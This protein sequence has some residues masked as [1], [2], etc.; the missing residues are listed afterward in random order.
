MASECDDV[1]WSDQK[2]IW[3]RI[4][5]AK[6]SVTR[7][8]T[9]IDKLTGCPFIYSM[10]AACDDTRK[11]LTEAFDFCVELHDRWSDLENE[12]GN[13]TASETANKSLA[14]YEEKQF[15]AL[16]KLTECVDKH[17]KSS[18]PIPSTSSDVTS[19]SVGTVPKL[20]TCKILF[21]KELTKENTPSEFRLW[22]AAYR[23]FHEASNLKLQPVAMQ[24]WYL[25]QALS[26][27]LQE[28]VERKLTLSMPLFGPA[29]CLDILQGEF[30]ILYPI[31]NRRVDFFQVAREPGENSEEYLRRLSSLA[32]MANLRAMTQEELTTFRFIGSCNDKRLRDKIFELK[33]KRKDTTAVRDAVAQYELQQK[34][35]AALQSK[36]APIAA[37]QQAQQA[38]GKGG[39]RMNKQ[40]KVPS[41]LVGR[42]ATCGEISHSTPDCNV[43]KKGIVCNNCGRPGHLSKVCF[44]VLRGQLKTT[45]AQAKSQ[46]IRAVTEIPE[47]NPVE[48]WVNRLTLNISHKNGSF[49]FS[50]FPDT[51]SAATLI[52]S[53]LAKK[54]GI[55]PT[56]HVSVNG[57]PVPMDVT[58][59]INLSISNR[60]INS[61]AV[62]SPAIKNEIIIGR[63][64][65]KELGVIPMQSRLHRFRESILSQ[66]NEDFHSWFMSIPHVKA[67]HDEGSFKRFQWNCLNSNEIETKDCT[68]TFQ[69]NQNADSSKGISWEDK[70]SFT[71]LIL[72]SKCLENII[73][74]LNPWETIRIMKELQSDPQT[75]PLNICLVSRFLATSS[76]TDTF[77]WPSFFNHWVYRLERVLRTSIIHHHTTS[78]H[79]LSYIIHAFMLMLIWQIHHSLA[80]LQFTGT[81]PS[82]LSFDFPT[83]R[84]NFFQSSNLKRPTIHSRNFMDS[85][86]R[87]FQ[88]RSLLKLMVELI[89]V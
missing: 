46:P 87:W 65:L 73:T 7:V 20:T 47:D 89:L 41:Q 16:T 32:E 48:P 88:M 82:Q 34:A 38:S 19:A 71:N 37:V 74:F 44:S 83:L 53:D 59:Q 54:Y 77:T 69:N 81:G 55:Q 75:M 42:C 76:N 12:A 26:A 29:G 78:L 36:A 31:F 6:S 2:S 49:T 58:T 1:D 13:K 15:S 10:P 4:P 72:K 23:R 67:K 35:E 85:H 86:D 30:R 68:R 64:D 45:Q 33:L 9:A 57:D 27:G 39:N 28:I 14:P 51:G 3:A 8:C 25:L 52:A 5:S 43:K 62:L 11:H 84:F 70:N 50:T 17:S 60:S 24:Q 40:C 21:P 61:T 18:A 80:S 56:K 63:D 22:V 66:F 79:I